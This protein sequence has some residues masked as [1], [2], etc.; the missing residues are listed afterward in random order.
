MKR[1]DP[2]NPRARPRGSSVKN[3]D[4]QSFRFAV[5]DLGKLWKATIM[6]N[7]DRFVDHFQ[8]CNTAD[9]RLGVKTGPVDLEAGLPR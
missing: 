9:V 5:F 2:L 4:G 8:H 1:A 3:I 6:S 7:P